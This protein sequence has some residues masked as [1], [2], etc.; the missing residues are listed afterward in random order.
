MAAAKRA[1]D[2]GWLLILGFRRP[3]WTT[4]PEVTTVRLSE[5]FTIDILIVADK[6]DDNIINRQCTGCDQKTKK[7]GNA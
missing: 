7:N 3:F 1:P 5:A 2:L 4:P 6:N